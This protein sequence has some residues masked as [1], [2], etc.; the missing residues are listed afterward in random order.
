MVEHLIE[1]ENKELKISSEW[2]HER[3]SEYCAE[4]KIDEPAV[5]T[6][7]GIVIRKLY[8]QNALKQHRV[9]GKAKYFYHGFEFLPDQTRE[10]LPLRVTIPSY[11]QFYAEHEMMVM[12]YPTT[13]FIDGKMCE[14]SVY[15]NTSTGEYWLR[16]RN[17]ELNIRKLGL[18][19]YTDLDQVFING[20]TKIINSF[21]LCHGRDVKVPSSK[22]DS[23]AIFP[24][25][26]YELGPNGT[27]VNQKV[28]WISKNCYGILALTLERKNQ[29]CSKCVHDVNDRIRILSSKDGSFSAD[30]ENS[31]ENDN[32]DDTEDAN[33]P[34]V[35]SDGLAK[36]GARRDRGSASESD[37]EESAETLNEGDVCIFL[38]FC[39]I[40]I[41][42]CYQF[43][44]II[45]ICKCSH[46]FL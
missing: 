1:R 43:G 36:G 7:L 19:N 2:L 4:Q 27:H 39:Y 15:L 3:Y 46:S 23:K 38:I 11:V 10:Q 28:I 44:D 12:Y 33:N 6:K 14:F 21:T 25:T 32:H 45:L 16:Y 42:I 29:T 5:S 13:L 18:T 17:N 35:R 30:P 40:L 24:H 31:F 37:E 20:I 26:M 9:K 22:K 8:G 34:Q 41:A